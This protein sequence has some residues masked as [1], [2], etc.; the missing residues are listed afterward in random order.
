MIR[1]GYREAVLRSNTPWICVSCYNCVTRC[2]QE[3]HITDVM[4]TLKSM[5][6]RAKLYKDSTAPDFSETFVDMVEKYGRSFEFGL[7]TR[8]MLKHQVGSLTGSAKM[9]MGMLS[10]QRI[11]M[12]PKQIKGIDQLTTILD[13]AKELEAG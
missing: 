12:K 4:Y 7:A 2:P 11:S 9:G 3:V 5:A 6:I 13:R 10:K 1:A 8:F